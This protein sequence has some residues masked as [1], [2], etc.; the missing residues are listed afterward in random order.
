MTTI[1]S[2][3]PR[4]PPK[5]HSTRPLNRSKPAEKLV[6]Y[7]IKRYCNEIKNYNTK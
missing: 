4:P 2:D 1:S 7:K 6:F 5:P 3:R